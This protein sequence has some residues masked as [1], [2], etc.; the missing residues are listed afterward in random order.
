VSAP[1]DYLCK[2]DERCCLAAEMHFEFV[3]GDH[4]L[5]EQDVSS[6]RKKKSFLKSHSC[7]PYSYVRVGFQRMLLVESDD[8][9][10]L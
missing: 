9:F 3:G 2:T 7:S 8:G 6:C 5:L 4:L 1:V 10:T